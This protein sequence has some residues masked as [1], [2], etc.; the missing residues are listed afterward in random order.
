MK[1]RISGKMSRRIALSLCI[2]GV[3][4]LALSLTVRSSQAKTPIQ[5]V[6]ASM[7]GDTYFWIAVASKILN[8]ELT[9]YEFS[10][11]AGTTSGNM[12]QLEKGEIP[13][14]YGNAM[15]YVTMYNREALKTSRI[16]EIWMMN[17]RAWIIIVPK[18]SPAKTIYD[19]KGKKISC[20]I[21]TGEG[22]LFLDYI[23]LLGLSKDDFNL[24][25]I[26]KGEGI[27]AFKNG[28]VD[29]LVGVSVIP[30]SMFSQAAASRRGA[31]LIGLSDSDLEKIM[32][33]RKPFESLG[34]I[35][36]GTHPGI[37]KDVKVI[38]G[39]DPLCAR[40]DLSSELVYRIAKALHKRHKDLI[41][42]FPPAK[43]STAENLIKNHGFPIHS[44][45]ERFLKELKLE[46]VK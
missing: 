7:G 19:L 22:A 25:F 36:A 35:P 11:R 28:S 12:I 21:R 5:M 2:A 30:S 18:D 14:A 6:S 16:R 39:W 17:G 15:V 46:G 26:G 41:Q 37:E 40:D 8:E 23:K 20:G 13:I 10:V 32:P 9:D 3:L 43:Y 1:R 31:R 38:M 27:E 42:A 44:G 29:A 4:L 34:I 24:F 33:S 45:T